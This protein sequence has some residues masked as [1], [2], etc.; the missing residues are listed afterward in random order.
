MALSAVLTCGWP[1]VVAGADLDAAALYERSELSPSS[2]NIDRLDA[3]LPDT[4]ASPI[5]V[6]KLDGLFRRRRSRDLRVLH[7]AGAL[8]EIADRRDCDI[9]CRIDVFAYAFLKAT[10]RLDFV[11]PQHTEDSP[12]HAVWPEWRAEMRAMHKFEE[13]GQLP[14]RRDRG[15]GFDPERY[16]RVRDVLARASAEPERRVVTL[17]LTNG[18]STLDEIA[19]ETDRTPLDVRRSLRVL[20]RVDVVAHAP[21]SGA[22]RLTLE[23]LPTVLFCMR[24]IVGFNPFPEISANT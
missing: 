24:A 6:H 3:L 1:P 15:R 20:S 14:R 23:T 13:R 2:D 17:L 7:L 5:V 9:H 10:A 4:A 21:D 19:G 12:F 8:A 16:L 11:L 22:W 18:P